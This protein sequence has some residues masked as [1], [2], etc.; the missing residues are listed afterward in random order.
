MEINRE[1]N[2]QPISWFKR[3]SYLR[4]SFNCVYLIYFK[5]ELVAN[6]PWKRDNHLWRVTGPGLQN[7]VQDPHDNWSVVYS[8]WARSL[9]L[10]RPIFFSCRS[11]SLDLRTF[12]L[13]DRCS[14]KIWLELVKTAF[15]S[16]SVG[17]IC[18]LPI[19]QLEKNSQM[20]RSLA[21]L[22]EPDGRRNGRG[23]QSL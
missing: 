9:D 23:G 10:H 5:S 14:Q 8:V 11:I 13:P 1:H 19:Y 20:A 2:K 21:F 4:Y 3:P 15:F 12:L 18:L 6:S 17:D 7:Q 22:P 16:P